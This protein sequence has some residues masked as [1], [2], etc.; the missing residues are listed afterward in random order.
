LKMLSDHCII[1]IA[2]D[3]AEEKGAIRTAITFFSEPYRFLSSFLLRRI[4][5]LVGLAL[6]FSI[7]QLYIQTRA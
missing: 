2:H 3:L 1:L 6:T 5:R 4:L 7:C